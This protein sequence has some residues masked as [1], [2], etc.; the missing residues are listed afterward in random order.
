MFSFNS[1]AKAVRRLEEIVATHAKVLQTQADALAE[2]Q[3]KHVR[4]RGKVYAHKLHKPE[5]E[6]TPSEGK[7]VD[8]MTREELRRSLVRSGRFMPGKPVSHDK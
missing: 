7:P 6:T 8:Q 4:L 3:D 1:Q 5:E 2:L